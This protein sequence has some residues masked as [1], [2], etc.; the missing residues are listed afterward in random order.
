MQDGNGD[1][2]DVFLL[3]KVCYALSDFA[4]IGQGKP[5]GVNRNKYA[6][7]SAARIG[8]G[9]GSDLQVVLNCGGKLFLKA[10]GAADIR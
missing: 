6:D 4:D 7:T 8:N 9:G 5:V 2:V 3:C 10:D 1:A